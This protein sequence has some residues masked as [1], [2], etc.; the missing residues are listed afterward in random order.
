[1]TNMPGINEVEAFAAVVNDDLDAARS[2]IRSMSARD[3]AVLEFYATTLS[4][5]VA[6][7]AQLVRVKEHRSAREAFD[8]QSKF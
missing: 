1:M 5:L 3:Q 8:P 6:H 7:E 2:L 4:D